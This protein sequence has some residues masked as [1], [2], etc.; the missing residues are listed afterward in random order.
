MEKFLK[1]TY[2]DVSHVAGY[3]GVKKLVDAAKTAGYTDASYGKVKSWLQ[4]QETY[5]VMKPA[6]HNFPRSHVKVGGLNEQFQAD[7]IDWSREVDANDGYKYILV[8]VD[9]F[10]RFA[11]TAALKSKTTAEVAEALAKIFREQRRPKYMIQTDAGQELCGRKAKAMYKSFNI[12]HMVS[13]SDKKASVV[14]RLIKTLRSKMNKYM[15][16]NQTRRWI[17][18]LEP[19]TRSYNSAI[20]SSTSFAPKDVTEVNEAYVRYR[21]FQIRRRKDIKARAAKHAKVNDSE[22]LKVKRKKPKILKP[23]YKVGQLVRISRLKGAFDREYSL[24]WA[25]EIYKVRKTYMRDGK[26]P[27]YLLND[28]V[29]EPVTGSFY[30]QEITP[31]AEPDRYKI[32]KVIKAGTKKGKK[33]L[34]KWLYWDPKYN[35]YADDSTTVSL[36]PTRKRKKKA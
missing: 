15:L 29:G 25:G 18:I 23:K 9:L 7:L 14:E 34:V 31:A 12:A 5:S 21:Q 4:R 17:N 28:W 33:S 8:T 16:E 19:V 13:R 3:S 11:C 30:E 22:P 35:S 24:K 36:K 1:K 2:Y 10:S 26:T 27:I 20:H 6:R 32:E